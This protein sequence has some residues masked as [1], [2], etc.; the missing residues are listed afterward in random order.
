MSDGLQEVPEGGL[1]A[2]PQGAQAPPPRL[3][4]DVLV[5]EAV[6]EDGLQRAAQQVSIAVLAGHLRVRRHVALLQRLQGQGDLLLD[7]LDGRDTVTHTA[8]RHASI[9]GLCDYGNHILIE[10]KKQI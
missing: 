10:I 3:T 8:E 5:L 2:G 4:A 1:G 9:L 6:D 7:Q